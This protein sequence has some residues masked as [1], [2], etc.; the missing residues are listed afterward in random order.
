MTATTFSLIS[1]DLFKSLA[2]LQIFAWCLILL[3]GY[4]LGVLVISLLIVVLS[5]I[6]F[7]SFLFLVR[8]SN[9]EIEKEFKKIEHRYFSILTNQK[10]LAKKK[11]GGGKTKK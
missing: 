4:L 11:L 3:I 9:L 1:K 6:Q 8:R 5:L 10:L 2:Y 7:L